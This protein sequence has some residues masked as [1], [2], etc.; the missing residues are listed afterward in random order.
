MFAALNVWFPAALLVGW[1]IAYIGYL[2]PWLRAYRLTA[3]LMARIQAEEAMGLAWLRLRLQGARTALLL[4]ATS[5]VTG[6]WGLVEA[7]FGVDPS[8]LAPFQD[9]GLWKAV[10]HDEMALRAAAVAT[11][12]A[13]LLT[14]R[15]KLRDIRSVPQA[16]GGQG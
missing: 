13:A 15:G 5:L 14:L 6:S 16:S 9:A 12:A 11:F 2:R 7:L 1:L 8:A 3:G 4:F 10:L